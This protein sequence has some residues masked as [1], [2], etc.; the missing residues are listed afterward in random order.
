MI[1][2]VMI[3]TQS[4][5]CFI[6]QPILE[7]LKLYFDPDTLFSVSNLYTHGK[8]KTYINNIFPGKILLPV[9]TQARTIYMTAK[10]TNH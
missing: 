2:L 9:N 3:E 4:K 5:L 10:L 7:D 8:L 1:N 6:R